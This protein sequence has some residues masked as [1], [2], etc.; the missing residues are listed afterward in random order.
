MNKLPIRYLEYILSLLDRYDGYLF[1]G[2]NRYIVENDLYIKDENGNFKLNLDYNSVFCNDIDVY[3]NNVD[4]KDKFINEMTKTYNSMFYCTFKDQKNE[5]QYV[6]YDSKQK[7]KIYT[8]VPK[9]SITIDVIFNDELIVNDFTFNLL[10]IKGNGDFIS[11]D[12]NF[13]V[14]EI[15]DQIKNKYGFMR[16]YCYQ[17]LNNF[18]TDKHIVSKFQ[19]RKKRFENEGYLIHDYKQSWGEMMYENYEH[20]SIM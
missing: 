2:L 7:L 8:T 14:S 6:N 12:E 20:C 3:F 4:N 16:P 17:V 15:I 11:L 10:F 13:K 9:F 5:Y 19:E 18:E 1:G